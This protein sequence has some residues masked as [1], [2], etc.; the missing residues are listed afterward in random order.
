MIP[1]IG[2][3]VF[4]LKFRK[5]MFVCFYVQWFLSIH[6]KIRFATLCTMLICIEHELFKKFRRRRVPQMIF[7]K[8]L[9][10]CCIGNAT[11]SIGFVQRELGSLIPFC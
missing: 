11:G 2:Y 7:C 1:D 5:K 10:C 4:A 9:P 8:I 3:T 6:R